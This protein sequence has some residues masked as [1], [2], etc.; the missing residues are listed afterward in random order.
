MTLQRLWGPVSTGLVLAMACAAWA[1]RDCMLL[2]LSMVLAYRLFLLHMDRGAPWRAIAAAVHALSA[3]L[4][5]VGAGVALVAVIAAAWLGWWHPTAGHPAA[6][7]L[8]LV[9]AAAWC[10]LSRGGP[11]EA[12]ELC[13]WLCVL[14]GAVV[15]NE[16]YRNGWSLAPCL[17]V[18]VVGMML[19]WAGWRLATETASAMLRAGAELG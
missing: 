2:A 19:L 11:E 16:L 7:L 8:M 1:W 12:H 4:L 9:A 13:I 18:S 17:F 10:C 3:G 15:A 6:L 5:A 14:S